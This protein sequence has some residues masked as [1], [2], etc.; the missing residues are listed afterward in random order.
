MVND[1]TL[2][3]IPE[4][5]LLY[6]RALR[7][8]IVEL[9]Q[10][11]PQQRIAELE[12]ANRKLRVELDDA[13]VVIHQQQEQIQQQQGRLADALAKP[14]TNS[15]NSSLPPSSDRFH[16]KRRPPL[17]PGQPRKKRGAQPG[18]PQ[19]LRLL[20]PSD[21]VRETIP[22]QPTTCRRCGKP[23]TGSDPDP[24][25]HQVAELPVVVPDVVEYQLHRLTC[26]CCHISTCGTLP[27][28]VK[29]QFGPRLEA[30]LA[31]L[32]SQYRQGLRPVVGLSADLWGLNLSTGMV[33]KLRQRTADALWVPWAQV[34]LYVRTQNVNIDETTWREGKKRAYLWAAVG[35]GLRGSSNLRPSEVVL[36]D[37]AVAVVLVAFAAGLPGDDRPGQGGQGHR[38]AS[39]GAQQQAVSPVASTE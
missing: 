25:R 4:D 17:S 31:L 9:E 32:A 30:T 13:R 2:Q 24:L 3:Q 33:S 38:P 14:R 18:H 15:T 19:H 37:Q 7:R 28:A 29:G 27:P 35:R 26:P 8:R 36:V 21:Q 34:A 16:C 12:A 10:T 6:L 11:A 1:E 22:C 39:A 5:V 20:V 23:L